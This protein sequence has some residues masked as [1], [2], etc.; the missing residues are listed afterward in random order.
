MPG[1]DPEKDVTSSSHQDKLGK[2]IFSCLPLTGHERILD[3]GCGDGKLSAHIASVFPGVSVVGIDNSSEMIEYAR[4]HHMLPNLRFMVMAA[5]NLRFHE[6]FDWVISIS[7]LHWVPDHVNLLVR[8]REA[9]NPGGRTFLQFGGQDGTSL[10]LGALLRIMADSRLLCACDDTVP[11]FHFFTAEIYAGFVA[12][13]G[14]AA[15]RIE[16][17]QKEI[18]YETRQELK[19]MI[20]SVLLAA[21]AKLPPETRQVLVDDM[22]D[23]YL[24]ECPPGPGP[25]HVS[26]PRL[27]VELEK[28]RA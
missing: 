6:E 10:F 18:V 25:I 20:E 5:E 28:R 12:E 27:E 17:V 9:L 23:G 19:A 16:L 8:I 26:L 11:S 1:W 24:L 21:T 3:I 13:A 15:R 4:Q 2:E 22:V 14:I 7:C